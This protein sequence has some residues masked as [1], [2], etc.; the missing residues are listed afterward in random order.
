VK[1]LIQKKILLIILKL[2]HIWNNREQDQVDYDDIDITPDNIGD[3]GYQGYESPSD[4]MY[5]SDAW[6]QAQRDMM[7]TRKAKSLSELLK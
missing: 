2:Q 7:E 5:N 4:R 1:H 3:P 6:V